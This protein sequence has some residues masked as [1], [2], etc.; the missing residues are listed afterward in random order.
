M[1][2]HKLAETVQSTPEMAEAARERYQQILSRSATDMEFRQKLLADPHA[3][4][5][6]YEG[7][8]IPEGFNV[9]FVENKADA[10]IVLPDPVDPEAELSE[11]ELEAVSGG[12]TPG[13]ISDS[14]S[15]RRFSS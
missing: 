9:V 4:I 1:S 11:T 15:S 6:E 2:S 7:V 10:T 8:T 3:A 14:I 5:A 12:S 13:P